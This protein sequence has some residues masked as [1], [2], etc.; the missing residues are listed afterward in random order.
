[1]KQGEEAMRRLEARKKHKEK[2]GERKEAMIRARIEPSL[3]NDV[4]KIFGELGLSTTEAI[5]L[6]YNQVRIYHG[7]PF[8]VLIP[9]QETLKAMQ[10]AKERKGMVTFDT[11]EDAFEYLGI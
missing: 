8:R 5:T 3:K 11:A 1:L 2:E 6:F 7:L 9:N 10:D 4:E